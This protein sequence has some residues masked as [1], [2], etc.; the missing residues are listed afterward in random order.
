MKFV[1][2][3]AIGL[4]LPGI[5]VAQQFFT[6][7]ADTRFPVQLRQTIHATRAKK[8]DPVEF[9]TIEPV[10]I[11]HGIVVPENAELIGEVGFVRSDSKATPRSWIRIWVKGLRWKS[12]QASINAVV[13]AI[14]YAPAAYIYSRDHKGP[15]PTFLEGIHISSHL[16]S[17]ASTDFFSDSKEVVLH[18]GIRLE[19]RHIVGTEQST[20]PLSASTAPKTGTMPKK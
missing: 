16:F 15:E 19:M 2:C 20:G 18:N 17:N 5:S 11:G 6:V 4:L 7:D 12:G 10:L 14:F 8:G 3:F 13:D 1:Y 9:R